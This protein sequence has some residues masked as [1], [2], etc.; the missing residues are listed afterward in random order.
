MASVFEL[1][2][3]GVICQ[4]ATDEAGLGHTPLGSVL[5]GIAT[6]CMVVGHLSQLLIIWL[7]HKQLCG[8]DVHVVDIKTCRYSGTDHMV[9]IQ[10]CMDVYTW[11]WFT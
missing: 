8:H 6:L 11:C 4:C 2:L 10:A 7:I 9:D 5:H 1:W 3:L